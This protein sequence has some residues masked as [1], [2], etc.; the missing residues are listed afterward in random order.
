MLLRALKGS[1]EV[2]DI[3]FPLTNWNETVVQGSNLLVI[4][5]AM[6]SVYEAVLRGDIDALRA[7]EPSLS[8]GCHLACRHRA[9]QSKCPC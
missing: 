8:L 6:A 1:I 3:R 5:F 4:N 7:F 2:K 9:I